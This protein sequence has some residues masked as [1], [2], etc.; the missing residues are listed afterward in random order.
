MRHTYQW[1]LLISN[2]RFTNIAN[3]GRRTYAA[4]VSAMDD[5]IGRTMSALRTASLE[6][7]TLIFF[8]SDN[9]GPIIVDGTMA[10]A[11]RR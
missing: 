2:F 11:T 4:M 6:E 3:E 5:A 10:R 9:G 1:R 8:L 7:N